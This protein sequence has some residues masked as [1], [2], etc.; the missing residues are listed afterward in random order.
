MKVNVIQDKSTIFETEYYYLGYELATYG[1][2][3]HVALS[4]LFCTA[5]HMIWE[6]A[7]TRGTNNFCYWEINDGNI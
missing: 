2:G 7:N 6:L 1:P 5:R 4:R 3:P